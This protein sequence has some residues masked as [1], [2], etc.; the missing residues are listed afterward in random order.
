MKYFID[1]KKKRIHHSQHAGDKCEFVTT[2][3]E[4]REFTTDLSYVEKLVH[5]SNYSKCPHCREVLRAI[6]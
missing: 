2:P 1:H 6:K 5:K 4:K 3:I